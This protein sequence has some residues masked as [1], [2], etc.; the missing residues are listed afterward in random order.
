MMNLRKMFEIFMK[1]SREPAPVQML[2]PT[3]KQPAPSEPLPTLSYEDDGRVKLGLHSFQGLISM[4]NGGSADLQNAIENAV[5]NRTSQNVYA[6]AFEAYRLL[7]PY[8][9]HMVGSDDNVWEHS[10][11]NMRSLAEEAAKDENAS[12]STLGFAGVVFCMDWNMG[13]SVK[14]YEVLGP[15][16]KE[17]NVSGND[18]PTL[19]SNLAKGLIYFNRGAALGCQTCRSNAKRAEKEIR[20]KEAPC[21]QSPPNPV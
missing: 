14:M 21:V 19:G 10:A 16:M 15:G 5:E 6:V 2:E 11:M 13:Q 3:P 20:E 8:Q 9:I 4:F 7:K 18:S 12:T 17:I 1:P